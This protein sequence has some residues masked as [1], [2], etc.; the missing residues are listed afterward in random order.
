[1]KPLSP[2]I[3]Q[4]ATFTKQELFKATGSHFKVLE[5][6]GRY[7]VIKGQV[8]LLWDS[9]W[10]GEGV[11]SLESF[12]GKSVRTGLELPRSALD[13]TTLFALARALTVQDIFDA[14]ATKS[15]SAAARLLVEKA[16]LFYGKEA[17]L[18]LYYAMDADPIES[19]KFIMQAQ[20]KH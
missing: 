6:G 17:E 7:S 12:N 19:F 2:A 13:D 3:S 18:A 14:E 11:V 8:I 20:S 1:M 4:P 15:Y 5:N 10:N 16:C 9:D